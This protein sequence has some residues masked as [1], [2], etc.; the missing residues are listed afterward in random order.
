MEPDETLPKEFVEKTFRKLRG[1]LANKKCFDCPAKNPQWCS[2]TY[3]IFICADCSGSHRRMG[4]HITFVRSSN[5]D[6]W[7]PKRLKRMIASGNGNCQEFFN[8]H[9]WKKAGKREDILKKYTSRAAK[10]YKIHLDQAIKSVVLDFTPSPVED[11]PIEDMDSMLEG[12]TQMNIKPP[13]AKRVKSAPALNNLGRVQKPK[14]KPSQSEIKKDPAKAEPIVPRDNPSARQVKPALKLKTK[15]KR[16]NLGKKKNKRSLSTKKRTSNSSKV[17]TRTGED[18]DLDELEQ[19]AIEEAA[20]R[21]EAEARRKKEEAAA[22][23]A[24][25][26]SM[27]KKSAKKKKATEVYD[28]TRRFQNAKSISSEQMF[29]RNQSDSEED[30]DTGRFRGARSI[31]SDQYFGRETEVDDVTGKN[32]GDSVS[33]AVA[34]AGD[35]FSQMKNSFT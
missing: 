4:V 30:F 24:G 33:D 25:K 34:A 29:G 15:K 11:R 12:M 35:W 27:P 3:G 22:L 18:F 13:A 2:V 19:Q 14:P 28:N 17:R 7:S 1:K 10:Q 8:R 20:K 9:G 32:L 31:G 26:K 23:K 6:T 21:K 16:L 5:L